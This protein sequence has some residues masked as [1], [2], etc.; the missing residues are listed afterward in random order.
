MVL[1]SAS[2]EGLSALS[3]P[4]Q[5]PSPL[6]SA[7][8]SASRPPLPPETPS[9]HGPS[10]RLEWAGL[11]H[12]LIIEIFG[13]RSEAKAGRCFPQVKGMDSS[14]ALLRQEGARE[15]SWTLKPE[16]SKGFLPAGS[17]RI[18]VALEGG[19]DRD[20]RPIEPQIPVSVMMPSFPPLAHAPPGITPASQNLPG[21]RESS[22]VH[23]VYYTSIKRFFKI[24]GTR[25]VSE[26]Y[27]APV[28]PSGLR[29]PLVGWTKAHL[30]P[31]HPGPL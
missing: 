16:A 8:P 30:S 4:A 2:G 27:S 15:V 29:C 13:P 19:G 14:W 20:S 12:V 10:L 25:G 17:R 24:L 28:I 31:R 6:P 26:A 3:T 1:F 11:D 5:P 18:Q 21:R 7:A 23:F 22:D 9:L